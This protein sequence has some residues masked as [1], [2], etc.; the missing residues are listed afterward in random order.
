MPASVN[1]RMAEARPSGGKNSR[2]TRMG[3]WQGCNMIFPIQR[4]S[5]KIGR[6]N[7]PAQTVAAL[8]I[9]LRQAGVCQECKIRKRE[10]TQISILSVLANQDKFIAGSSKL[11]HKELLR[12]NNGQGLY[13]SSRI[14]RKCALLPQIGHQPIAKSTIFPFPDYRSTAS[15]VIVRATPSGEKT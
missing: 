12:L 7:D 4:C 8:A 14:C 5:S 10:A 1:R 6:A 11:S 3:E 9:G 15:T 13:I 2:A